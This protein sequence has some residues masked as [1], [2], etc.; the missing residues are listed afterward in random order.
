MMEKAHR[1]KLRAKF[2]RYL[3]NKRLICLAIPDDFEFM[4]PVLV[5]LLKLKVI[6]FLPVSH[7]RA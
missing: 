6:G 5:S 4:G 1:N 3:A 7:A 2:G